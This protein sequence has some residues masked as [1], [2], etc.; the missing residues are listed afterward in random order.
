MS[1]Y[2]VH[3]HLLHEKTPTVYVDTVS[4]H[5]HAWTHA[6]IFAV[7]SYH[8]RDKGMVCAWSLWPHVSSLT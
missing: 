1:T 8:S 3:K 6:W 7:L 5:I 2:S 4:V